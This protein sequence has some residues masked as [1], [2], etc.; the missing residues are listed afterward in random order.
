MSFMQT[1]SQ[2]RLLSVKQ[3]IDLN[4]MIDEIFECSLLIL[5]ILLKYFGI[6]SIYQYT[7]TDFDCSCLYLNATLVLDSRRLVVIYDSRGVVSSS[8]PRLP[9]YSGAGS[10]LAFFFFLYN[11]I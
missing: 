3:Q 4:F 1:G 6:Q 11:Y 8:V 2:F 7:L 10:S 5:V 9:S